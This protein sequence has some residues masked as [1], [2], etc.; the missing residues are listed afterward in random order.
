M[1]EVESGEKVEIDSDVHAR[2]KDYC[3][4]R[5]LKMGHFVTKLVRQAV[6]GGGSDRDASESLVR[7]DDSRAFLREARLE[8]TWTEIVEG[9]GRRVWVARRQKTVRGRTV[10][11]EEQT[12]DTEGEALRYA[13]QE[14]MKTGD[15]F[16][17]EPS[18]TWDESLPAETGP[19][20][21][22]D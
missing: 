3:D 6:G 21:D 19:I 8:R 20:F 15:R 1:S 11:S 4:K 2:L 7:W 14:R 12:F 17:V 5:G 9:A 22:D 10:T 13:D 16:L 18:Y